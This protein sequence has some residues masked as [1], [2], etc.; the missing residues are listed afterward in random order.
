MKVLVV[1][2]GS[3]SLKYQLFDT[4]SGDVLA[5]GICERIGIDGALTHKVPG[6]E[7]YSVEI[8]LKNHTEATRAVVEA[9]CSDEHGC[10]KSMDEI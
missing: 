4:V 6:A 1:N 10:S 7:P 3:S 2:A 5:K 8:S 9:L